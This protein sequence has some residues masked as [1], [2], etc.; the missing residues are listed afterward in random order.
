AL[1]YGADEESLTQAYSEFKKEALE[2]EEDYCPDSVNTDG[3]DATRN[4]IRSVFIGVSLILCFLHSALKVRDKRRKFPKKNEL[5]KHVWDSY[6]AETVSLFEKR[7]KR[8]EKWVC[9][10]EIP[11]SVKEKV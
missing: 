4:A 5:M 11:E 6:K 9:K 7:L 2:I 8:L 1:A 10:E 3:W